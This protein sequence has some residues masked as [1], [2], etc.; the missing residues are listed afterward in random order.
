M[1][2][3]AISEHKVPLYSGKKISDCGNC[4]YKNMLQEDIGPGY[5]CCCPALMH[6]WQMGLLTF[7]V[8]YHRCQRY[9]FEIKIHGL[10]LIG[11]Q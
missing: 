11:V 4:R 7:K 2:N 8:V 10:K 6:F 9:Y 3:Q 1:Q 5:V